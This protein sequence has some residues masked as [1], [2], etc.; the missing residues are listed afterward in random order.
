MN[1]RKNWMLVILC[2]LSIAVISCRSMLD[3]VTPCELP[4]QS[5]V[6]VG[7]KVNEFGITSLYDA[8]KIR[9]KISI[10]HRN[11]QIDLLRLAENDEYAYQDAKT[12]IDGSIKEAQA[13]QDIVVGSEGQ[14]FSLLGIL[15]GFTGG[16]AIGRMLKR[17]GDYSPAEYEEGIA[18]IKTSIIN[19]RTV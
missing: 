5:A 14:P 11:A 4:E 3:R 13:L 8:L 17:K 18:K 2:V 9:D 7:K 19:G 6:Y 12:F 10:F 16:T 1:D 15:A